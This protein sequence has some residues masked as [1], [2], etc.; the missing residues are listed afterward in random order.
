M[1]DVRKAQRPV[2]RVVWDE[3]YLQQLHIGV[4]VHE[5]GV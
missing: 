2:P 4:I 1:N 3:W 5:R